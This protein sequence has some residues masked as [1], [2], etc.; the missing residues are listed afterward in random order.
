MPA[1]KCPNPS[2][3]F[4]FDPTQVP[5]GA[6][7]TC[8]RCGMR[9]TLGPSPGHA[10]PAA[11]PGDAAPVFEDPAPTPAVPSRAPRR[12]SEGAFPILAT[13]GG[14]LLVLG[15]IAGAVVVAAWVK[16][17]GDGGDGGDVV[18]GTGELRVEDKNFAYRMPGPP[19][20]RDA[21]TQNDLGVHA[22]A[23]HRTGE[24]EAWAALE[25]KDYDRQ[26]PPEEELKDRMSKQLHRVFNN[27]PEELP[28]EPATWAGHEAKKCQ[29]RGEQKGTGAVCAGECYVLGY[30]GLGYW[31]YTWSAERDAP[32][33]AGEFD[34]L[35]GR[36]RTL[37]ERKNWSGQAVGKEVVW[38]SPLGKHPYRL[39]DKD[40]IWKRPDG[41]DPTD[42][43]PKADLVLRAKLGQGDFVPQA[44]VVVLVL[45]EPGD[46]AEVG[47]EYVRKRNS[48]DPAVFGPTKITELPGAEGGAIPTTRL[49]V[50]RGGENASKSADKFV[51]CA[52]IKVG[53]EVIVA[54]GSCEWAKRNLWEQR[55]AQFVG[56]LQPAE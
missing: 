24:P 45:S 9:F 44:T 42:E 8:P 52:A 31:F 35:R 16:T 13:I 27:L 14:V 22:F 17:R 3:P 50:S 54:E 49:Q 34:D 33:V 7:L 12:R 15:L 30:K 37:D 23:L 2:C 20:E 26:T 4:L 53:D 21:A 10:P 11:P 56:S 6:V 18:A 40:G 46:A 38:P 32:A 1:L 28:L 29:F 48:P 43:D 51:V 5:P 47:R 55:L 19:W 36:F 39:R 41:L 25:V